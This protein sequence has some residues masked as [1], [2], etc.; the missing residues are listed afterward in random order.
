M[1]GFF[2][3]YKLLGSASVGASDNCF[4]SGGMN[5]SSQEVERILH[6]HP[7]ILQT[8]VVGVPDAKWAEA[9]TAFVILRPGFTTDQADI[10]QHCKQNLAPYKV[11]KAVHFVDSLPKDTQGKLLKRELRRMY[12]PK[13]PT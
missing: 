10:I 8:A 5:V 4:G 2:A 7:A 9:V 3:T 12:T 6:Q 11:P 13:N 1:Y